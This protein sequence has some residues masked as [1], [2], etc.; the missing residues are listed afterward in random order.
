MI[1]CCSRFDIHTYRPNRFCIAPVPSGHHTR[2]IF[3]GLPTRYNIYFFL[4]ASFNIFLS[5]KLI[6]YFITQFNN[7]LV[8]I[9]IYFKTA[10]CTN[11]LS[12]KDVDDL[13]KLLL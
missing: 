11:Y 1:C 3:Y 2:S 5:E 12:I 4:I 6:D 13:V 8:D 7:L 9:Y 10:F